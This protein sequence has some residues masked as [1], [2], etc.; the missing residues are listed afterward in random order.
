M[1]AIEIKPWVCMPT[2]YLFIAVLA[3]VALWLG[4][5]LEFLLNMSYGFLALILFASLSI[6][7]S[8][9]PEFSELLEDPFFAEGSAISN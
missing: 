3:V 5:Y 6:A 2:S 4:T 8:L 7:V 9:S 1:V